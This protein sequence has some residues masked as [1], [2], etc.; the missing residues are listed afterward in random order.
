MD[1]DSLRQLVEQIVRQ[2]LGEHLGTSAAEPEPKP[3]VLMTGCPQGH[4]VVFRQLQRIEQELGP[5]TAALSESFRELVSPETFTQET[6]IGHLVTDLCRKSAEA[7]VARASLLL[8]GTLCANSRAKF[9]L[10]IRDSLPSILY[11]AARNARLPLFIAIPPELLAA[12]SAPATSPARLRQREEELSILRADGAEILPAAEIFDR[13][14][15]FCLERGDPVAAKKLREA[16]P[17]PIIIAEDVERAHRR[18]LQEWALPKE[19][20]VTMA[21]HDRARDLGLRLSGGNLP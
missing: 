14:R 2:V 5:C 4:E 17:R 19:A 9:A 13:I 15:R 20:I 16:G 21:A 8:V 3:L 7:L 6:G 12:P 18:G 1:S 10:G 11:F